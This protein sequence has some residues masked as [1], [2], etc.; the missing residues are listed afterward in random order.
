M[1]FSRELDNEKLRLAFVIYG[2]MSRKDWRTVSQEDVNFETTELES[3]LIPVFREALGEDINLQ[4]WTEKLVEECRQ[5]LS[6]L[7]P[8]NE[9]EIEFLRKINEQGVI[10]PDLLT[11]DTN[12]QEIITRHPALNWK[13]LNENHHK[14]RQ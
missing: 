6:A 9:N 8:L 5:A 4:E 7:L 1:R 3:Q 10:E 14:H 2:A 13:A 12:L 11:P